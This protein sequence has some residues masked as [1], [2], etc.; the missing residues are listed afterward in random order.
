MPQISNSLD[1]VTMKKIGK[2]LGLSLIASVGA[3]LTALTQGVDLMS[4]LLIGLG[5][6][7]A[8]LVNVAK[9]YKKG[10]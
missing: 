3:V 6:F 10:E 2:S 7:G 9:E 8:F 5:T 1:A 4:A